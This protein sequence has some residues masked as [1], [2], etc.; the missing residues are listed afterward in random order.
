[1]AL[2]FFKHLVLVHASVSGCDRLAGEPLQRTLQSRWLHRGLLLQ[3]H[4]SLHHS[5]VLFF[6]PLGVVSRR[7]RTV[8]ATAFEANPLVLQLSTSISLMSR[9]A[10]PLRLLSIS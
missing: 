10:K 9:S 2:D 7:L 6:Q 3:G 5:Q 1:M 4:V 8:S